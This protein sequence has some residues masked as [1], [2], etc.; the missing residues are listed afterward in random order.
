MVGWRFLLLESKIDRWLVFEQV[1]LCIVIPTYIL[2]TK[3][4]IR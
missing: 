4:T 3:T 2:C 1:L